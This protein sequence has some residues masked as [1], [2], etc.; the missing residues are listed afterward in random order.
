MDDDQ[1]SDVIR[2]AGRLLKLWLGLLASVLLV[3]ILLALDWPALG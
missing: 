2:V 1:Q 3:R